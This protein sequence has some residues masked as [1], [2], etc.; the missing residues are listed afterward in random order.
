MLSEYAVG[1][2]LDKMKKKKAYF[3]FSKVLFNT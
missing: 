2:G 1:D 3:K